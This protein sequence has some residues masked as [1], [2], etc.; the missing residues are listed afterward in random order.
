MGVPGKRNAIRLKRHAI[1]IA[2]Q[3]PEDRAEALKVLEYAAD[4]IEWQEDA[5]D[6]KLKLVPAAI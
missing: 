5:P 3:L 1:Q 4:L 2:I 6:P